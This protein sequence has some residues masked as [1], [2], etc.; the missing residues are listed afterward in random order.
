MGQRHAP[1]PATVL[2]SRDTTRWAYCKCKSIAELLRA[3][4]AHHKPQRG[5]ES[6]PTPDGR[7]RE[8]PRFFALLSLLRPSCFGCDRLVADRFAFAAY[9]LAIT[10]LRFLGVPAA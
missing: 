10:G 2:G 9:D 6:D 8:Y 1:L 5:K 4:L 3:T 7:M